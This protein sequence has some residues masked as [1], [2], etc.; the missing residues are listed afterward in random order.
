MLLGLNS[1]VLR[2][3]L[4]SFIFL[5]WERV[6]HLVVQPDES[7]KITRERRDRQA[8]GNRSDVRAIFHDRRR[9]VTSVLHSH[10]GIGRGSISSRSKRLLACAIFT[11][12]YLFFWYCVNTVWKN[13]NICTFATLL[14]LSPSDRRWR[15]KF[16]R[17]YFLSSYF[18]KW[19]RRAIRNFSF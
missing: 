17:T 8:Q 16:F 4:H 12:A 15:K 13:K 5:H 10:A 19:K 2:A 9:R 14:G 6:Q 7:R 11:K 3:V 18:L 1:P